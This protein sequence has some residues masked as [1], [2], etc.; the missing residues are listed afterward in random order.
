[1]QEIRISSIWEKV[2]NHKKQEIQKNS[3]SEKVEN[4]KF[5]KIM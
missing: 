3:K 1:M 2:G 5:G 4:Q